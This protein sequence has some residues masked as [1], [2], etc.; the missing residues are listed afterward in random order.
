MAA[1]L[2]SRGGFLLV[3][4]RVLRMGSGEESAAC[5][6]RYGHQ[7]SHSIPLWDSADM[8]VHRCGICYRHRHSP[9][10]GAPAHCDGQS[11]APSPQH[12]GMPHISDF[13]EASDVPGSETRSA[14]SCLGPGLNAAV[15]CMHGRAGLQQNCYAGCRWPP[16]LWLGSSGSTRGQSFRQSRPTLLQP[17]QACCRRGAPCRAL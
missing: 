10:G 7:K 17:K 13:A 2:Q 9:P 12:P 15:T 1:S 5:R 11:S 16:R 6:S 4:S 14:A 8:H 3:R